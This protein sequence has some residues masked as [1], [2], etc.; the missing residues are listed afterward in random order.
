MNYNRDLLRLNLEIAAISIHL[1][2]LLS[3]F[4]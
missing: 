3:L 4:T 2:E 1:Y